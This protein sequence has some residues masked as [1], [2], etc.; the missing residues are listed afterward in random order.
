MQLDPGFA[1]RL[2]AGDPAALRTTGLGARELALLHAAHPAA[3]AAD[4]DGARRAQFLRNV[5]SEFQLSLALLGAGALES[6]PRSLDF[7]RALQRGGRLPLALAR[8]LARTARGA[9]AMVEAIAALERRMAHAR[10]TIR[11]VAEPAPGSVVLAAGCELLELGAGALDFATR[12]RAALDR[13]AP[14]PRPPALDPGA[15]E[16]LLLRSRSPAGP[17]RLRDVEVEG[18]SPALARF[19]CA[20]RHPLAPADLAEL[21]ASLDASLAE[22]DELIGE[23]SDA[24]IVL[25]G[26]A[27]GVA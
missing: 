13:G 23:L 11:S 10:R 20:A 22:L 8:H 3:I 18:L 26:P 9:G 14:A 7:H 21:A 12:L 15:T 6:F 24:G 17:A 4:R 27:P 16:R 25:V 1:Q 2:S 5:G 19:L